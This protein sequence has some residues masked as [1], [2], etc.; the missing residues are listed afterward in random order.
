MP[1][2][3]PSLVC[4][5]QLRFDEALIGKPLPE[6][7]CIEKTM[8]KAG[9]PMTRL[10]ADKPSIVGEADN[11]ASF[12]YARI[13]RSGSVDLPG[14]RQAATFSFTF[15]YAEMPLDPRVV[16]A[17][18]IE[19]HLGTVSAE[20][21]ADGER[22]R[23][24]TGALPTILKTRNGDGTPN[25][26]TLVM[27]GMIDEWDVHHTGSGST[28]EIKGR[29]FR[30]ILIDTPLG[31][32]PGKAAEDEANTLLENLDYSK[33]INELV[34]QILAHQ[35]LFDRFKV[36][37]NPAEW[38]DG[39]VPTISDDEL[40]VRYRQEAKK[41]GD[42]SK[43]RHTPNA[44][45]GKMSYW[46]L[47][48]KFCYLV[49]SIPFF[50]GLELHIRPSRT[51]YDQMDGPVDPKK[52]PTP[53]MGGAQ[54]TKDNVSGAA[55]APGLSWRRFV[56]G[57]DIETLNF[58]RKYGG[59]HR[60]KVVRAIGALD[61]VATKAAGKLRYFEGRWPAVEK[62]LV[63]K[64]QPGDAKSQEEILN[65]PA[66]EFSNPD[67]LIEVARA[68]YE[69]IGRGEIGGSVETTNL[70]SFGGGNPD[71]DCLRLRPGDG[72]EFR[73]D[74]RAMSATNLLVSTLNEMEQKSPEEAIKALNKVLGDVDLARA[75]VV[76]S[77]GGL[78]QMQRFFRVQTVKYAW[79]TSG[80]KVSFDFQNYF[81]ARM[82]TAEDTSKPG[83]AVVV[84]TPSK[85]SPKSKKVIG[86][87]PNPM[88][89]P[90]SLTSY[91]P[92]LSTQSDGLP[93][94]K[95]NLGPHGVR[96]N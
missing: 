79:S 41:K 26:E 93:P 19:I 9:V 37:V 56:Y 48:V 66:P 61:P 36:V 70:A 7:I 3:R 55:I 57:R 62:T 30:G 42:K 83:A 58:T 92:P 67:R 90:S 82:Q 80:I 95:P 89:R 16:R 31:I 12:L 72:V 64:A 44:D 13:P 69:E 96:R 65:I 40:T 76:T 33:P 29:D 27:V 50:R 77:R 6:P 68:T 23:D 47:I 28:V 94:P 85:P 59:Y 2:Y 88:L 53:F 11:E 73:V 4:V 71:A 34:A 21:Y 74:A 91:P 54:R 38:K 35:P 43:T 8:T 46:D 25:S 52:N 81:V 20:N 45:A 24:K 84:Q 22:G 39:E 87:A 75:I 86:T 60:P 17:A 63:T 51:I 18:S 49:G 14:Y 32:M 78:T 10:T 15:D 1:V 5:L